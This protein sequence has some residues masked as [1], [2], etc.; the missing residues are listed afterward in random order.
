MHTNEIREKGR[1]G[2][3][4]KKERKGREEKKKN[5]PHTLFSIHFKKVLI[6]TRLKKKG[7]K[8]VLIEEIWKQRPTRRR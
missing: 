1:E 6:A 3:E 2:K 7:K 5:V 4:G 8:K